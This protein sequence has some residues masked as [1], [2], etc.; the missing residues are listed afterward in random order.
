MER[1]TLADWVAADLE[2]PNLNQARQLALF[3]RSLHLIAPSNAPLNSVRGV[4]LQ[5]RAT[6]I[7]QRIHR[8]ENKTNLITKTIKNIWQRALNTPIDIRAKWL[9]G[10]LH[11][12][13]I[14]VKQGIIVGIIDWGD[15][16]SGDIATDLACIWMLFSDRS[17]R[18]EAIAQYSM[19]EQTLQRAKGWAIYFAITLLEV[20]LIDN[21]IQAIIGEQTL[22]CVAEDETN[23]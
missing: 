5:K 17:A 7:E 3:L 9:H 2:K 10:D 21:P 13:N 15:I 22:R 1:S 19:S 8:L 4:P 11:P 12:G 14:L 18:Q 16:T 6:V 23:V 20:G